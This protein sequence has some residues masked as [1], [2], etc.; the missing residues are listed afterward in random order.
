MKSRFTSNSIEEQIKRFSQRFNGKKLSLLDDVIF[1]GKTML[2]IIEQ[3]R[4]QNVN[5]E[6]VYSGITIKNGQVLLENSGVKVNSLLT[7]DS[8]IDEICQRDFTIGTPFSGRTVFTENNSIAGA[9]YVKPFGKPSEWASIPSESVDEFSK[10]CLEQAYS[11]W[12]R[13]EKLSKRTISTQE[14]AKPIFRL[15]INKSIS[16]AIKT[17]LRRENKNAK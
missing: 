7:Y 16:Q 4:Q 6:N 1:E 9:P 8:V 5:V 2:Q 3:F 10:F 17:V 13:T 11:L 12:R 15:P 14:L